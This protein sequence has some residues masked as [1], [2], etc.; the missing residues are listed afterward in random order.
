MADEKPYTS[1]D[2]D[3]YLKLFQAAYD[4]LVEK[5]FKNLE[6]RRDTFYAA[7]D[8]AGSLVKE[9]WVA[10]VVK[11][12]GNASFKGALSRVRSAHEIQ[13]LHQN[14]ENWEPIGN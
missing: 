13:K 6:A 12:A 5:K 14:A 11:Q 9:D 2:R 4:L 8:E 10:G 1:E 7:V 3:R